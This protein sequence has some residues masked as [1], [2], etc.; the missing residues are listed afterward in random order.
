MF[1]AEDPPE[2]TA[3]IDGCFTDR[4]ISYPGAGG[5]H[6]PGLQYAVARTRDYRKR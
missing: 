3:T 5:S 6:P 2:F 4:R 1:A